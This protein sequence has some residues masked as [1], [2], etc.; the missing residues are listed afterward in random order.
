MEWKNLNTTARSQ[1]LEAKTPQIR[2]VIV[3]NHINFPER[4][5]ASTVPDILKG[6]SD[7]GPEGM[8][9]EEAVQKAENLV[10]NRL[11]AMLTDLTT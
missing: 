10:R 6:Y 11:Q 8:S 2:I 4:W 3:K 1:V 9:S 7:I 5:T